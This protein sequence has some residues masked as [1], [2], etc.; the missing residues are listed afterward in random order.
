MERKEKESVLGEGGKHIHEEREFGE[1]WF[2]LSLW[3]IGTG[4]DFDQ[5]MGLL[6][7]LGPN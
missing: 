1:G 3:L 6:L 4:M 5:G 2:G 7:R